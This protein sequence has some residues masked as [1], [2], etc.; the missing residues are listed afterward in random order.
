MTQA[1][2]DQQIANLTT[3]VTDEV[4]GVAGSGGK[5]SLGDHGG[6]LSTG[7][8]PSASPSTS[9][10]SNERRFNGP[11][12]GGDPPRPADPVRVTRHSSI[13]VT[14]P[15]PAVRR[16]MVSTIL[17]P[18]HPRRRQGGRLRQGRE[19][20]SRG[21]RMVNRAD[22]DLP[23]DVGALF[24]EHGARILAFTHRLLGDR[25][26]AEDATQETFLKAHQ[27]ASS[28]AGESAPSTWLFA[29][30]RNTCLD[31]LRARSPKAFASLEEQIAREGGAGR[32]GAIGTA[33]TSKQ[34]AATEAERR[35]YLDAVR[36]G[37]LLAT[38]ACLSADQRAAFVLRVLGDMNTRDT[39][40]VLGRTENAVRMLTF[41][42]R[43]GLKAFLCRNC[44]VYDPGN[45]CR[46][47]NLVDFSLAQGWLGPDK[48]RVPSREAAAAAERAAA[49]ISDV[50][51]LAAVYAS[52][53]EPELGLALAARIRSSLRG[54]D[55]ASP[56]TVV[57]K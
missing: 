22:P 8:Q 14:E 38:L 10:Q 44:S 15:E 37:C 12:P 9:T 4:N 47:A 56:V 33:G 24:E 16:S 21:E 30:A 25:A 51:R 53:S 43:H 55:T 3:H 35:W 45:A 46:C 40:V 39:A 41:R 52:L 17:S 36:E 7:V 13:R 20:T 49:A 28:F 1:Q 54:L 2:A 26:D 57:E 32:D 27:R 31:R 18:R 29:I 50:A 5:G 11:D 42:A 34:D 19:D 23:I 6:G 48:R